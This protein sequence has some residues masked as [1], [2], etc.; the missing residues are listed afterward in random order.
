MFA[1]LPPSSARQLRLVRCH[2][3]AR[4]QFQHRA[5]FS[6]FGAE[7]AC[8]DLCGTPGQFGRLGARM[9]W[10]KAAAWPGWAWYSTI[11]ARRRIFL[12]YSTIWRYWPC[13]AAEFDPKQLVGYQKAVVRWFT[14][15]REG[16]ASPTA[17]DPRQTELDQR[18]IGVRR[19][20][21]RPQGGT[22]S[23]HT[24]AS[25]LPRA[26]TVAPDYFK[27]AASCLVVRASGRAQAIV[28]PR[29]PSRRSMRAP[30]CGVWRRCRSQRGA[31]TANRATCATLV[32]ALRIS[33]GR[34]DWATMTSR[35]RRS[36]R[37]ESR[38]RRSKVC[39]R[40]F[41]RKTHASTRSSKPSQNLGGNWN[42]CRRGSAWSSHDE[43]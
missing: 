38:S 32:Q 19:S 18:R 27:R 31:S 14:I 40:S 41:K 15:L 13:A 17:V 3:R 6:V 8:Q 28:P 1:D 34:L 20:A 25:R 5:H 33:M 42:W 4:L 16:P 36:M 43:R 10:S 37:K 2:Q 35:S 9:A 22:M 39:I 30:F 23:R 7:H 24:A 21:H 29:R 26:S 11:R 12:S